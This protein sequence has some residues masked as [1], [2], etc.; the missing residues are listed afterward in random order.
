MRK[1]WDWIWRS[2][3]NGFLNMLAPSDFQYIEIVPQLMRSCGGLGR[4]NDDDQVQ[5]PYIKHVDIVN[6][7]LR[8]FC[9]PTWTETQLQRMFKD[10]ISFKTSAFQR[11]AKY[12][13]FLTGMQNGHCAN[14]VFERIPQFSWVEY[15]HEK[16]Y[17]NCSKGLKKFC[18]K[19]SRRIYFA[20]KQETALPEEISILYMKVSNSKGHMYRQPAPVISWG[21][22]EEWTSLVRTC[23]NRTL[24]ATDAGFP[25]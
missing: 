22:I 18:A 21:S 4:I 3:K 7:S 25:A 15:L 12:Q 23:H 2:S 9:S 8:T 6:H 5:K 1:L 13:I 16:L 17:E 14:Q 11:F 10:F 19:S 24:N 20:L